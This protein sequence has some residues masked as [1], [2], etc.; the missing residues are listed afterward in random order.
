MNLRKPDT[1]GW[2]LIAI[3]AVNVWGLLTGGGL[4][5]LAFVALAGY[6]VWD[7]FK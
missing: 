1:W 3:L 5:S 4:L 7:Y 6:F 2:V